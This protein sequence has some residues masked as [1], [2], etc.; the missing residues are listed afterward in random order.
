MNLMQKKL[1]KHVLKIKRSFLNYE[2]LNIDIPVIIYK[3]L[4]NFHLSIKMLIIQNFYKEIIIL[5]NIVVSVLQ[6]RSMVNLRSTVH[7]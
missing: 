5:V 6:V 2:F 1:A 7:V 3:I 4:N